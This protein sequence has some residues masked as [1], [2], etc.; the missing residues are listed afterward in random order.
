MHLSFIYCRKN[1]KCQEIYALPPV[2]SHYHPYHSPA[3]VTFGESGLW[4]GTRPNDRHTSTKISCLQSMAPY[5]QKKQKSMQ[6]VYIVKAKL[7]TQQLVELISLQENIL[8]PRASV[9]SLRYRM[10]V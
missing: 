5:K 6:N 8:S 7:Y 4:L 9:F 2:S 10:L 3:D 1:V